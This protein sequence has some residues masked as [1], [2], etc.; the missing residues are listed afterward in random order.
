MN[1]HADK[2]SN[3]AF[4]LLRRI[5]VHVTFQRLSRLEKM[6]KPSIDLVTG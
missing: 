3:A 6:G 4:S 1:R 5:I 2:R